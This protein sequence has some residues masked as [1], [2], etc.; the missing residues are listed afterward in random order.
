M[1]P[2]HL[3]EHLKAMKSWQD[4]ILNLDVPRKEI[5]QAIQYSIDSLEKYLAE[6]TGG[7]S[8]ELLLQNLRRVG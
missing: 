7:N 4:C 1:D 2:R 3:R 8:D 6:N 5:A